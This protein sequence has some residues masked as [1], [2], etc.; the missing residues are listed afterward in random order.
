MTGRDPVE[1]STRQLIED[2]RARQEAMAG[3]DAVL[4]AVRGTAYDEHGS[5]RVTVDGRGKLLDLWL[6]QDAVRWGPQR[7]G[8]LIVA[9]A[10]AALAQATQAGYNKLGPILGDSMTQAIELL[11]GRAAPARRDTRPGITAEEF[12]RRRD[13]RMHARSAGAPAAEGDGVPGGQPAPGAG[14][15]GGQAHPAAGQVAPSGATTAAGRA[16]DGRGRAGADDGF[17]PD[18]PLAFDLSSLRSDR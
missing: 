15:I 1:R 11:S 9:V 5:V 12:Q 10:D 2:G 18:D 13:E 8:A 3:V 7:L 16:D 4:A 14:T 17:D 6:R